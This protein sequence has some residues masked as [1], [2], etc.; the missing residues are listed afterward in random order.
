MEAKKETMQNVELYRIRKN[1]DVKCEADKTRLYISYILDSVG[2]ELPQDFQDLVY[3][4]HKKTRGNQMEIGVMV[5]S[6]LAMAIIAY[7]SDEYY[8]RTRKRPLTRSEIAYPLYR[9]GS[10]AIPRSKKKLVLFLAKDKAN[11]Y[12]PTSSLYRYE[13]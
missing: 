12:I 11:D 5:P 4:I 3:E 10:Q 9:E 7:A 8:G 6:T 13:H 2:R 1:I